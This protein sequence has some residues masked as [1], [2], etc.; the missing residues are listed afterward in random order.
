MAFF[1]GF[2]EIIEECN[3]QS[4]ERAKAPDVF[5]SVDSS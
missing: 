3:T 1:D 2:L 4:T 5:P